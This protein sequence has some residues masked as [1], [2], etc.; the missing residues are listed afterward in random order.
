M[1]IF[2]SASAVAAVIT[3]AAC[4]P[5]AQPPADDGAALAVS[6]GRLVLPAVKGNPAAAYFTL[7]NTGDKAVRVGAVDIEGAGMTMLH[8]T[9]EENGRS[10]MTM[11]MS[12]EVRPGESLTL[13]PGG[14]HVMIEGIPAGLA[15]GASVKMTLTFDNGQKLVA[16][17]T[18]TSSQLA[19]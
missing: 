8:E 15:P 19:D 7:S 17:L 3:L 13:S 10:T 9:R 6:E 5:S 12:P 14:K 11:L 4:N 2:H 18:V 16:P 1:R